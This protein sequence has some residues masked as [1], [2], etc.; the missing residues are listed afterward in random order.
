VATIGANS[1]GMVVH[2][3]LERDPVGAILQV[4]FI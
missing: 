1:A 4:S 3:V 2:H